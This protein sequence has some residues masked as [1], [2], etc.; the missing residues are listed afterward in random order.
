M[1]QTM[2]KSHLILWLFSIISLETLNGKYEPGEIL[3]Q[4]LLQT[5]IFQ[6]LLLMEQNNPVVKPFPSQKFG[7]CIKK[8]RIPMVIPKLKE[9]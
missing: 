7:K 4:L 2:I 9:I 3:L 5:S 1:K 6:F 8:D